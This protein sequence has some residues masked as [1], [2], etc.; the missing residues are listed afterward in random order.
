MHISNECDDGFFKIIQHMTTN[1]V[2]LFRR[3]EKVKEIQ[4]GKTLTIDELHDMLIRERTEIL[5][6]EGETE[7]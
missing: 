7:K 6:H 3:G 5:I 4:P 1:R 2:E